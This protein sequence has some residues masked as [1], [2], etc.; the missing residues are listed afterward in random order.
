MGPGRIV[1]AISYPAIYNLL[2][3]PVGMVPI[4]R[5]NE[6]DQVSSCLYHFS[7]QINCHG[8]IQHLGNLATSET[9]PKS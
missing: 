9:F 7:A 1:P 2:D 6:Q 4:T 5:V 8:T 3:F